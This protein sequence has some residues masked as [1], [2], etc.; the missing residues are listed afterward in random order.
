MESEFP[1]DA[2]PVVSVSALLKSVRETLER[3]FPLAWIAGEISNFRPAAS[4]QANRLTE[5]YRIGECTDE[6]WCRTF[7]PRS[8]DRR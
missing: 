1:R 6:I 3:R 5:I 4:G 2:A 8:I 7:G